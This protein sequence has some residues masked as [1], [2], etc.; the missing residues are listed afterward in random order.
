MSRFASYVGA[1]SGVTLALI[2]IFSSG[3]SSALARGNPSSLTKTPHNPPTNNKCIPYTGSAF[4]TPGLSLTY[5]VAGHE[6]VRHYFL[7]MVD[8]DSVA[9]ATYRP[10]VKHERIIGYVSYVQHINTNTRLIEYRSSTS[11][12]P[13]SVTGDQPVGGYTELWVPT[14]THVGDRIPLLATTTVV[15]REGDTVWYVGDQSPFT[16]FGTR[17]YSKSTGVFL[18]FNTP[19]PSPRLSNISLCRIPS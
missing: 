19:T 2:F 7:D 12:A 9:V 14:T 13:F 15:G 10:I 8:N 4:P 16:T 5:T 18:G 6:T 11:A 17:S 1:T 3:S